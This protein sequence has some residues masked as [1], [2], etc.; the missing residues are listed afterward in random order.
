MEFVMAVRTILSWLKL[1]PNSV[2]Y[3]RCI[4]F[5]VLSVHVWFK[6]SKHVTSLSSWGSACGL[7]RATYYWTKMSSWHLYSWNCD[8]RCWY[9]QYRQY[10][11]RS[12]SE[13]RQKCG[14]GPSPMYW[15]DTHP[16]T[17]TTPSPKDCRAK[18]PQISDCH[19][20]VNAGNEQSWNILIL[21]RIHDTCTFVPKTTA[22]ETFMQFLCY[23]VVTSEGRPNKVYIF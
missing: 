20:F 2:K 19:G 23:H 10:R 12:V 14:I 16:P 3:S 17:L 18:T 1:V 4:G 6:Q 9:R 22:N 15:Q 7:N 21:L 11:Q 8:K 13:Y 5:W